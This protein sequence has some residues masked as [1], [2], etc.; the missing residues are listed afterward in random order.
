M[1]WFEHEFDRKKA[2]EE[3]CKKTAF[4]EVAPEV[5]MSSENNSRWSFCSSKNSQDAMKYIWDRYIFSQKSDI[6]RL[7]LLQKYEKVLYCEKTHKKCREL[8][9]YEPIFSSNFFK[10]IYGCKL[11]V[12]TYFYSFAI[13]RDLKIIICVVYGRV[14]TTNSRIP[15]F[16]C[17]FFEPRLKQSLIWI[18][19]IRK[20][21]TW[22]T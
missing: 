7:L 5:K 16:P 12:V 4:P 9:L 3:L 8:C 15:N 21:K 14:Q 11:T 22:T 13:F 18:V 20:W 10:R 19:R 6:L 1:P 17:L 2:S